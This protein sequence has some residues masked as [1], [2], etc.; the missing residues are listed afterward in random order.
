MAT[1]SCVFEDRFLVRSIDKS[2][3]ERVARISAKSTGFDAEL[4]LDVNSDLLPV[5]NKAMLHILITNSLLPSGSD[6]NLSECNDIPTLLGDYEYAMYGK[7][8]KFE[9]ISSET[10]TIYA[11]FGGLL[12]SLTADKQVVADLELDMKIYLLVRRITANR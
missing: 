8:F 2:K 11:S 3:F 10:R 9:E 5:N 4:L 6:V 7:I 12:M 1:A